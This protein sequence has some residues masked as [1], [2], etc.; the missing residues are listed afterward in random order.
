M[1]GAQQHI[2][3]GLHGPAVLRDADS[4]DTISIAMI[5]NLPQR[6]PVTAAEIEL[7]YAAFAS[8]LDAL[9]ENL[10]KE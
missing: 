1:S 9:F 5:D 2:E 3:N 7:L 8:R 10:K 6:L 4:S